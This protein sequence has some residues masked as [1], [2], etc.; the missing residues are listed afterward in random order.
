LFE[1]CIP[2]LSVYD[3]FEVVDSEGKIEELAKKVEEIKNQQFEAQKTITHT[4]VESMVADMEEYMS[5]GGKFPESDMA[6]FLRGEMDD[7]LYKQ[8]EKLEKTT[9]KK[10]QVDPKKI[11]LT[12]KMMDEY[13]EKLGEEV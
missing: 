8:L 2:K 1:R 6:V 4:I 13:A 7:R 9:G 10:Y 3:K 12:K 5:R 11:G